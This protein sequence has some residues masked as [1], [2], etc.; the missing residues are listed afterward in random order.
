MNYTPLASYA[1]LWKDFGSS[2]FNPSLYTAPLST[3]VASKKSVDLNIF[4]SQVLTLLLTGQYK[5][6]VEKKSFERS[7]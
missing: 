3:T 1:I 2:F 6:Y 5:L 7:E 4:D